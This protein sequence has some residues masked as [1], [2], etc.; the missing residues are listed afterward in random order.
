MSSTGYGVHPTI[1]KDLSDS[2][3][4][5]MY[6]QSVWSGMGEHERQQLLQETVNREALSQGQIGACEVRFAN[7]SNGVSGE[8]SGNVIS[9]NREMFVN[10]RQIANT[11]YGPVTREYVTSNANALETALH[12]N[13]HAWQNQC[14]SGEIQGDPKLTNEYR[15]NDF[16]VSR[17]GLPDGTEK[18]GSQYLTGEYSYD[19]YY[20]Q[21]TERDAYRFSQ[22]RATE[23]IQEVEQQYGTDFTFEEYRNELIQSGYQARLEAANQKYGTDQFEQEVNKTLANQYYGKIFDVDPQ[24]EGAVKLEMVAS[25]EN[26][27]NSNMQKSGEGIADY[28]PVTIEEYKSTLNNTLNGFYTHSLNDP[29]ISN[30]EAIA[31][32]SQVAENSLI[33]VE[34]FEADSQAEAAA[35]ESA[36]ASIGSDVGEGF[37]GGEDG[38]EG[39]DGGME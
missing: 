3:L 9:L 30:E 10:D 32:T 38:G 34:E 8:Q 1:Y 21:S 33:A 39:L 36:S 15:A 26:S 14:I 13:Q 12:E 4:H 17:V 7:L 20:F 18:L 19:L 31:Q 37:D 22:A 25:Y 2:Q 29:S 6:R 5:G 35:G 27:Y 23:I 24:I 28:K 16:T 11:S